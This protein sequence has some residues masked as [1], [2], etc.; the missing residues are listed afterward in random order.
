MGAAGHAKGPG[1]LHEGDRGINHLCQ[2]FAGG[3]YVGAVLFDD[4]G[5]AAGAVGRLA[6]VGGAYTLGKILSGL[7]GGREC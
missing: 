6:F 2:E 5:V 4:E 3:G 7:L 1:A